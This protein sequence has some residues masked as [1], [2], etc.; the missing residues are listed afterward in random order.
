MSWEP[1]FQVYERDAAGR[2]AIV[3]VDLAARE[4]APLESHP[5]RL[6]VRVDL[7]APRADGVPSPEELDALHE[8]ED[9]LADGAEEALDAVYVGR[10]T[11]AGRVTH[12]LYVPEAGRRRKVIEKLLTSLKPYSVEWELEDDPQWAGYE[13][14]LYPD[15]LTEKLLAVRRLVAFMSE[16]GDQLHVPRLIDHLAIFTSR[17]NAEAAGRY[18]AGM[19][20][21]VDEPEAEDDGDADA[22]GQWTLTFHREDHL[23]EGRAEEITREAYSTVRQHDGSYDGWEACHVKE[24]GSAPVRQ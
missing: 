12:L 4:F 1:D 9:R 10:T 2:R 15:E 14:D 13:E 19:G 20:F 16:N 17:E 6:T 5:L 8:L 21:L 7:R 23:A 22:A 3:T 11:A 24:P 18:L